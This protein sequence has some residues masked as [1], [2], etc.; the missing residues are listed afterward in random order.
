ML[1]NFKLPYVWE[2]QFRL[3]KRLGQFTMTLFRCT[4]T[5]ENWITGETFGACISGDKEP[6][7]NCRTGDLQALMRSACSSAR[8]SIQTITFRLAS[9]VLEMETGESSVPIATEKQNQTTLIN[10]KLEQ[11]CWRK[12]MD[13]H[14]MELNPTLS[15]TCKQELT[16]RASS[17]EPNAAYIRIVEL[18]FCTNWLHC[19]TNCKPDVCRGLLHIFSVLPNLY[20]TACTAQK[21]AISI[22]HPWQ[23]RPH[24]KFLQILQWQLKIH[25]TCNQVRVMFHPNATISLNASCT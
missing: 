17:S 6:P 19:R 18:T 25:K 12:C 14:Y 24:T 2:A 5:L 7:A 8:W 22:K 11:W 13:F 4:K 10:K 20:R 16:K 9:P 1:S 21:L 3:Q 15:P 23:S